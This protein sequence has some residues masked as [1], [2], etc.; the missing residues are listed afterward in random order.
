MRRPAS[1]RFF[2]RS[3]P[4]LLRAGFAH[5]AG[6]RADVVVG[7]AVHA[8]PRRSMLRRLGRLHGHLAGLGVDRHDDAVLLLD[9]QVALAAVA[10]LLQLVGQQ[11]G[12][13]LRRQDLE[14]FQL[15]ADAV[16]GLD[17]PG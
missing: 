14:Q 2:S 15:G 9:Q 17:A 12:H 8:R 16:L 6:V 13:L 10:A 5:L 11:A 4:Q 3:C 7:P 1:R